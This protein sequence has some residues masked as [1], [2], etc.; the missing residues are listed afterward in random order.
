MKLTLRPLLRFFCLGSLLFL[1]ACR[2]NNDPGNGLDPNYESV[3]GLDGAEVIGLD[4]PL[5]LTDR[6]G[7]TGM[8]PVDSSA[9]APVYFAFDSSTVSPGELSKAREVASYLNNYPGHAVILQGHT[10]ERG[11]REYNLA[12]GERRALAVR[13]VLMSY[14]IG[15]DRIQTLSFGE[16]QP[17]VAGFDESA[18]SLN[19]RVDF[20]LMR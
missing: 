6:D 18:W 16:E 20:Q 14:G 3:G 11:S 4:D 12:L 19:R 15:P 7:M 10:D 9:Y 13:E 17:A 5:A 1:A 8:E 2:G